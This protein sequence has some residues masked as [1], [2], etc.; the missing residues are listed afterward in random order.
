M[1]WCVFENGT[2]AEYFRIR[3]VDLNACP[4]PEGLSY[5]HAV[6]A[7]DMCTTGF[8][9]A[10]LANIQ[11]GDTVVVCGIGPVGLMAVAASALRGA[12]RIIAIGNR[13]NTIDLAKEYGATDIVKY[14]D[15][16]IDDQVIELLG[17]KQ[18]D[19]VITAGGNADSFARCINMVKPNGYVSNLNAQTFDAVIPNAYTLGFCSHKHINGGLC[20]GGRRRLERLFA[21]MTAGRLDPTKLISHRFHG[22]EHIQD[23]YDLMAFKEDHPE[24][25][26]PIVFID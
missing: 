1:N 7:A 24:V 20:P 25:V 9:G 17:G 2:F 21:L 12:G 5:E 19:A 18:P 6:M 3:Q 10:E 8:H 11:F 14:K 23:A 22:F 16:P 13:Q 15:G 26:K 4:I